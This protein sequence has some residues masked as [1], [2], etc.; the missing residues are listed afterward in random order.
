[1]IVIAH[2]L[3]AVRP[4]DRIIGMEEGRIVEIGAHD[5]LLRRGGLYARLWALQNDLERV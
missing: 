5:E 4:C 3:Q 2:R 1:M